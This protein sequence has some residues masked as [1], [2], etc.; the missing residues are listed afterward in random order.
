M[1]S[2]ACAPKTGSPKKKVSSGSSKETLEDILEELMNDMYWT[3]K[4][5]LKALPKMA[6]AACHEELKDTFGRHRHETKRQIERIEK[7]FALLEMKSVANKCEV[8]ED[9]AKERTEVIKDNAKGQVRD[10]ALISV[11]QKVEHYE[12]SAYGRMRTIAT[13]LGKVQ[14]AELFE[15][16]KVVEAKTDEKLAALAESINQLAPEIKA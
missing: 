13:V 14:C 7:C 2:K 1:K 8:M 9:L 12:I 10:A 16:S 5:L 15:E 4:H 11:A 3:E 6:K